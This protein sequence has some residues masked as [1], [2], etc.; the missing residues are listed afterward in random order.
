MC[1]HCDSG[2]TVHELF[3]ATIMINEVLFPPQKK[4]GKWVLSNLNEGQF[5]IYLAINQIKFIKL[6]MAHPKGKS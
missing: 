6:T 5:F 2:H 3:Y 1:S 4:V